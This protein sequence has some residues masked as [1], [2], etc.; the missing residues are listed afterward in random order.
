MNL[1]S[2]K[3]GQVRVKIKLAFQYYTNGFVV[4]LVIMKLTHFVNCF[5]RVESYET[6]T[7]VAICLFTGLIKT[8]KLQINRLAFTIVEN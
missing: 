6:K 2:L 8:F 1:T 5:F 3:S 7:T 4:D